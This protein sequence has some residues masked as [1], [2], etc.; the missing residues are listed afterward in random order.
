MGR[1]YGHQ[2]MRGRNRAD[3]QCFAKTD[4]NS[5]GGPRVNDSDGWILRLGEGW[6]AMK[7]SALTRSA[8]LSCREVSMAC[9][10]AQN[11]AQSELEWVAD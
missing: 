11:Q 3:Y 1:E 7:A 2:S 4:L 6:Q 8:K 5:Q 10:A 9:P